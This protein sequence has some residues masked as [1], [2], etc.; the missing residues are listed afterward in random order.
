MQIPK[1][2]GYFEKIHK[3]GILWELPKCLPVFSNFNIKYELLFR[4]PRVECHPF[5]I[6]SQSNIIEEKTGCCKKSISN[7]IALNFHFTYFVCCNCKLIKMLNPGS[8][9]IFILF[10]KANHWDMLSISFN[11]RPKWD[12]DFM[13]LHYVQY[14]ISMVPFGVGCV[15][16][17]VCVC[18]GGGVN[19]N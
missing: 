15:C 13:L 2:T 17:C 9:K 6:V 3:I 18:G 5:P 11:S 19:M 8:C 12:V 10:L 14:V 4:E 16:V 7:N 1:F